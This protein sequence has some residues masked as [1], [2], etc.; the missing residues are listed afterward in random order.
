MI[1][2]RGGE[3]QDYSPT[4]SD[5]I[6]WVENTYLMSQNT[7]EKCLSFPPAIASNSRISVDGLIFSAVKKDAANTQVI[8]NIEGA[9]N[10][11]K[12]VEFTETHSN[13]PEDIRYT[14]PVEEKMTPVEVSNTDINET[15]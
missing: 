14:M 15:M 7:P 8:V 10:K 2:D 9:Q 12:I 3:N 5:I 4:S 6:R 1:T 11:T 13:T